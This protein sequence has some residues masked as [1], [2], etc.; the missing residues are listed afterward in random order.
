LSIR[1]QC[2]NTAQELQDNWDISTNRAQTNSIKP[3]IIIKLLLKTLPFP[4]FHS[5]TINNEKNTMF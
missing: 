3:I 1:F 5:S 2:P 4:I